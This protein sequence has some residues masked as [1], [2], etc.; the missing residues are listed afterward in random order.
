MHVH[1]PVPAWPLPQPVSPVDAATPQ[2]VRLPSGIWPLSYMCTRRLCVP[3]P[4]TRSPILLPAPSWCHGKDRPGTA[5]VLPA[6][7][8]CQRRVRV[9]IQCLLFQS[10]PAPA[11]GLGLRTAVRTV[12]GSRTQPYRQGTPAGR[13]G[14]PMPM[15]P[16][17]SSY[18]VM[19]CQEERLGKLHRIR[20]LISQ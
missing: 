1:V 19:W 14:E 5:P 11:V 8:N 15:R 12:Q 6:A 18:V 9:Q 2:T 7:A 4:W 10:V 13:W 17:P 16:P 3:T 20:A